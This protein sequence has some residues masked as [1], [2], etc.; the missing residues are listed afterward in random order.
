MLSIRIAQMLSS[1]KA[2][3][4]V[5]ST[6]ATPV[7]AGIV[8]SLLSD[9]QAWEPHR[10]LL[11]TMG[12]QNNLISYQPLSVQFITALMAAPELADILILQ[13]DVF[14]DVVQMAILQVQQSASADDLRSC[15]TRCD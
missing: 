5:D 4:S 3:N 15:S 8:V 7:S 6:P 9:S 10:E 11:D 13:A 14:V 12:L 2:S 1:H